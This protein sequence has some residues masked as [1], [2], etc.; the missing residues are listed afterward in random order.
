MKNQ[1][2]HLM[3]EILKV[4][5]VAHLSFLFIGIVGASIITYQLFPSS[6]KW[7]ILMLGS[8]IGIVVGAYAS[9]EA[10]K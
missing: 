7:L 9:K 1:L 4:I 2:N 5:K 3:V 6:P 8:V 10:V